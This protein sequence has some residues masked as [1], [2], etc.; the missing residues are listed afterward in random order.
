MNPLIQFY[1]GFYYNNGIAI[2]QQKIHLLY[3]NEERSSA[4]KTKQL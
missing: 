3:K 1:F 4:R 2:R